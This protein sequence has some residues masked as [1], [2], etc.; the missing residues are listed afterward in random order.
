MRRDV[1]E[2][3]AKFQQRDEEREGRVERQIV[4]LL[5]CHPRLEYH[6]CWVYLLL[7]MLPHF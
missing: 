3:L 5:K 2:I 1:Q 6:P 7:A 4:T